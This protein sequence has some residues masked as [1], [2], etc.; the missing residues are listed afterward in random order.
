MLHIDNL[1]LDKQANYIEEFNHY[2]N[3]NELSTQIEIRVSN[4]IYKI[5]II[6]YILLKNT[7]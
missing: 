2:V 7:I 5:I 6:T 4:N 1:T 3:Y